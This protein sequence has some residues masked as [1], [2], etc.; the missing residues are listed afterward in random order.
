MYGCTFMFVASDGKIIVVGQLGDGGIVLFNDNYDFMVFKHFSRK[1]DG[2][3][4]SLCGSN[5]EYVFFTNTYSVSM[6]ANVFI[7]SDGV[8]DAAACI[9][10]RD[11]VLNQKIKFATYATEL[12]NYYHEY[13]IN[14][15]DKKLK[16][17][18][19]YTERDKKTGLSR[20]L[21][22]ISP[23]DDCSAVLL[24]TDDLPNSFPLEKLSAEEVV[25]K[26]SNVII[27]KNN[28][29][30]I[31]IFN[32][33]EGRE[34]R[35]NYEPVELLFGYAVY[36]KTIST[37]RIDITDC[38]EIST[39]HLTEIIF[40]GDKTE[41]YLPIEFYFHTKA[42]TSER[43]L[44]FIVRLEQIIKR[45]KETGWFI[46]EGFFETLRVFFN[47]NDECFFQI[48][49]QTVSNSRTNY[50]AENYFKQLLDELNVKP[51]IKILVNE[52]KI[53]L[54]YTLS[55]G[56]E[57]R[58]DNAPVYDCPYLPPF[59]LI[60]STYGGYALQ[61]IGESEWTYQNS[62][63]ESIKTVK[64]N[65]RCHAAPNCTI[66]HGTAIIKILEG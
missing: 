37:Y 4:D 65:Q 17:F 35:P 40:N 5:P 39:V 49:P 2:G 53:Q 22:D 36:S 52:R 59:A 10:P 6:F 38:K 50:N 16:N 45:I 60:K 48:H 63:S 19:F 66:T 33:I 29:N 23:F 51:G 44:S 3:V 57:K 61:N 12:L 11:T 18:K 54:Y 26:N 27:L 46:L 28:S 15:T 58:F 24:V 34:C 56:S 41:K 30:Y 31:T 20:C 13:G 43:L 64:Q 14:A 42:L 25:R 8:F 32:S 47:D 9:P 21:T 55:Y 1:Y 62:D 7:A